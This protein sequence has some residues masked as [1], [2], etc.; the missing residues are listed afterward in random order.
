MFSGGR[1]GLGLGFLTVGASPALNAVHGAGGCLGNSPVTPLVADGRK[2]SGFRLAAAALPDL[3]ALLGAGGGLAHFPVTEDMLSG[4][5]NGLGFGFAAVGTGLGANAVHGAG[6]L[7]G[8]DPLAPLVAQG[9]NGPGFGGIAAAALA[10]LFTGCGTGG[11]LDGF[12]G[13]EGMDTGGREHLGF[14]NAAEAALALCLTG[15]GAGGC[16]GGSPVAPAVGTDLLLFKGGLEGDGGGR[17]IV[18]GSLVPGADPYGH[19]IPGLYLQGMGNAHAAK[20]RN[21]VNDMLGI[22][23]AQ[24]DY[25]HHQRLALGANDYGAVFRRDPV[26]PVA[27]VVGQQIMYGLLAGDQLIRMEFRAHGIHGRGI[28][29]AAAGFA[30]TV[31]VRI[32]MADLC[33]FPGLLL[34]A[35]AASP[36]SLA[37][38]GAGGS[39]GHCPVA[40]AVAGGRELSG[41]SLTAGAL[42]DLLPLLGASG[43]LAHFPGPKDMNAGGA[44]GLG[45]GGL[46]G[47]AGS[48][49]NTLLGAGGLLGG[50]PLAPLVAQGSNLSGF[51]LTA[52]ASADLLPLLGAGGGLAHF[53]VAEDMLSGGRNVPAFRLAAAGA[54]PLLTTADGAGGSLDHFPIAPLVAQGGNGQGFLG[55]GL[56]QILV[57]PVAAAVRAMPVLRHTGINAAGSRSTHMLQ[58]IMYAGSAHDNVAA[59]RAVGKHLH[60]HRRNQQHQTQEQRKYTLQHTLI[61][62]DVYTIR[63]ISTLL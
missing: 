37:L 38:G 48:G 23:P 8:G 26:V 22:L 6:G 27:G 53:P 46:T 41:L 5:R 29:F 52:G 34:A 17:G 62:P 60:R 3:L 35:A 16:L 61:P 47:L 39:L 4:G 19:L 42:T 20:A 63:I 51:G 30:A 1:D 40:P 15:G 12:P 54:G 49:A 2:L 14:G 31:L 56:Q 45:L 58:P 25:L 7:L 36:G 55:G 10:D 57:Q 44:D 21:L 50:D 13:T 33:D 43:G 59:V 32:H 9:G 11:S 18:G 28:G 24:V